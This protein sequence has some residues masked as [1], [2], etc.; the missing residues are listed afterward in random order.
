MTVFCCLLF[1]RRE[2]TRENNRGSLRQAQGR[3]FDCAQDDSF[4]WS[5]V[6]LRERTTTTA[7]SVAYRE[8]LIKLPAVPQ[9]LKSHSIESSYGATKV[10]PLQNSDSIQ[11]F[12]R[13]DPGASQSATMPPVA[14]QRRP[15]WGLGR[16]ADFSTSL[17]FGRNDDAVVSKEEQAKAKY[18]GSSLRSE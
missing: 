11:R 5:F 17:R 10:A 7:T 8:V 12:L 2:Q 16:E 6:S 1:V 4:Y 15:A 9:R 14:D 13:R 3:L 18:R